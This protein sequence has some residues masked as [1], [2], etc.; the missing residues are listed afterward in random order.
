MLRRFLVSLI[1]RSVLILLLICLGC[2]AQSD[3]SDLTRKIERQVRASYSVP[4]EVPIVV[5]AITPSTDW[6]NYDA[7]TVTIGGG[8]AKKS[9][10][11]FLVSKDR[12]TMLR[13]S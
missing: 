5:G 3:P 9:D 1:R 10:F 13:M 11:K 4:V 7:V 2:A 8:D 12:S 6:P